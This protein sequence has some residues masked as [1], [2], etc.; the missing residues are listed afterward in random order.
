VGLLSVVWVKRVPESK[1]KE[2]SHI[3]RH[4]CAV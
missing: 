3:L 2:I 1:A 4:S